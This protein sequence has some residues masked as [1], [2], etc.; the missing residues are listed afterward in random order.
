MLAYKAALVLKFRFISWCT[1]YLIPKLQS[2]KHQKQEEQ[3]E[4]FKTVG[5]KLE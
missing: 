3:W 1:T 2:H 5:N 4:F